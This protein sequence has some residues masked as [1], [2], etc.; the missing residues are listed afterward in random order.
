MKS[1]FKR[2]KAE[3]VSEDKWAA[4]MPNIRDRVLY[5]LHGQ[6]PRYLRVIGARYSCTSVGKTE[7]DTSTRCK[8]ATRA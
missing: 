6:W 7:A 2:M 3:K 8:N 4:A 5:S 1:A